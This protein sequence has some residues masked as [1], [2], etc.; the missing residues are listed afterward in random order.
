MSVSTATIKFSRQEIETLINTL[1]LV[2]SMD[3][4]IDEDFLKPYHSVKKDLGDI[5]KQLIEG[6]QQ[7]NGHVTQKDFYGENCE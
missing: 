5:R 2:L 3:L 4:P 6:E 1:D 7:L